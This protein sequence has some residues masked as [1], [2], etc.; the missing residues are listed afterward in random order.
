MRLH[1]RQAGVGPNLIVTIGELPVSKRAVVHFSS[2]SRC[3]R[4]AYLQPMTE[5]VREGVPFTDNAISASCATRIP[6]NS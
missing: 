1:Q 5:V 2:S 3:A 4:L 6:P